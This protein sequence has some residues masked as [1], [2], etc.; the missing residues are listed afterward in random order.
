LKDIA[1]M[2]GGKYYNA[3]DNSKLRHIYQSIDQLEKTKIS[4][5]EFSKKE[6]QF[7]V[8]S[9]LAFI[10]LSLEILIRNTILRKIP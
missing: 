8:F 7:Y 9:I 10:L 4:V 5:R 1:N 2:T 3:T 6:E